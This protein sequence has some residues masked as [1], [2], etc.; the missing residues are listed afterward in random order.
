MRNAIR[1]YI[2]LSDEE[3]QNLWDQATFVFDTNV[4]LNLYRYTEK[5]RRIL[6]SA[7]VELQDRL[8]MPNHVAHEFMKHR[9]NIIWETNHQ[10]DTLQS[11]AEKFIESCRVTLKLE[12]SDEDLDKL[13]SHISGWIQKAKEEN[14]AVNTSNDDSILDQLLTI[15]DGRVGPVFTP[16]EIRSLE[17][18]GKGRFAA[19]IPPG[20]KDAGKQKGEN[21]NNMF[22]DLI[23]W[24]QILNYALSEKKDIIFVTNDQKED[25]WEIL[26]NQT[27]GPRAELRKEFADYTSQRFHMY[28]I[29]NFITRFE[30][31]GSVRIDRNTIDEIES[32]SNTS[33]TSLQRMGLRSF[34]G[35]FDDYERD[36]IE[37]MRFNLMRIERKNMKRMR[38]IKQIRAKYEGKNMP[39]DVETMLEQTIT[40]FER[41]RKRL[42]KLQSILAEE[43]YIS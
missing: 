29:R 40:N 16:D 15:Y 23:V 4:L 6:L 35:E 20:Y 7:L 38:A 32:Y 10:Y 30:N 25:W 31:G 8:W 41:D 27:I 26:H 19:E 34:R 1:E 37:R 39:E 5:T 17:T 11:E 36:K 43:Y 18:E 24:K 22:G 33:I 9:N 14:V 42:E 21:Q 2:S 28:T 3:K 12:Q 13:R